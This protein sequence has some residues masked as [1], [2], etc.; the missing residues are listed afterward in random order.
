MVAECRSQDRHIPCHEFLDRKRGDWVAGPR[1]QGAICR[2]YWDTVRPRPP[3]LQV[4]ER[5]GLLVLVPPPPDREDVPVV[6][7]VAQD[8]QVNCVSPA[9]LDG[10]AAGPRS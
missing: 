6:M 3:L 2:G 9:Q 7:T 8:R 4:A 10:D 5:M 1:A